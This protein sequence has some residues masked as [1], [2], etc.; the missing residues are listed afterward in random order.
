MFSFNLVQ[1][2]NPPE[3][4]SIV[5]ECSSACEINLQ[6]VLSTQNVT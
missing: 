5:F 6:L 2:V 4:A 3:H 1:S